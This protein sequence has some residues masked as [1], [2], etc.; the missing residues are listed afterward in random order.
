MS[1]SGVS[2][3]S[4]S[5]DDFD[6]NLSSLNMQQFFDQLQSYGHVVEQGQE[7]DPN[8]PV[9]VFVN[10][11]ILAFNKTRRAQHRRPD[12]PELLDGRAAKISARLTEPAGD[13]FL[14]IKVNTNFQLTLYTIYS[15]LI[16]IFSIYHPQTMLFVGF[17]GINVRLWYYEF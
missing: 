15:I 4:S 5:D 13:Y 17:E 9:E 10:D 11:A 2:S 7:F 16:F 8:Q 3:E 12:A 6:L 1:N 14:Y